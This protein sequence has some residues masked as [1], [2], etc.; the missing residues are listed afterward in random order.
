LRIVRQGGEGR[1]G[2]EGKSGIADEIEG[3]D[4]KFFN[5]VRNN[6]PL[7]FLTGFTS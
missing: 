3:R 1:I 4:K 7:E 2:K 6:A 5:P